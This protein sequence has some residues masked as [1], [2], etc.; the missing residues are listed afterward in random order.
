MCFEF[1]RVVLVG[2]LVLLAV[3]TAQADY[4]V[5]KSGHRLRIT[6]HEIEGDHLRLHL[7]SGGSAD[8]PPELVV[9]Y[10]VEEPVPAPAAFG[11][12]FARKLIAETAARHGVDARLVASVAAVE[13]NFNSQAVSPKGALGVMQLMPATASRFAVR[14]AFDPAEN[15][16]AGVRYLKE[17]LG[18]FGNDLTLALAA[19]NA[20]PERVALY[21]TIPPYPETIAY[22]RKV[23]ARVRT[24]DPPSVR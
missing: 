2:T 12:E 16:E 7:A 20:G 8:V 9:G 23:L 15:V 21:G 4:A 18:R 6:A 13:S 3:G 24:S 1:K 10:E 19:Y 14:D 17:L 5:L 11:P 22:V